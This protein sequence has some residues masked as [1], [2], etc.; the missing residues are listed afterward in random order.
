MGSGC[1]DPHILDLGTIVLGGER[2]T[3][4]PGRFTPGERSPGT[5]DRRLNGPQNRSGRRGEE[6]DLVPNRTR[7]PTPWPFSP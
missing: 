1:I 6:I 4:R 2:S 5:L 3:S 7:I